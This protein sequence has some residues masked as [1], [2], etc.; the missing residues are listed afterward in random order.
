M[1]Y[2]SSFLLFFFLF[3]QLVFITF[4]CCYRTQIKTKHPKTTR[5]SLFSFCVCPFC[6]KQACCM[7]IKVLRRWVIIFYH[8]RCKTLVIIVIAIKIRTEKHLSRAG[9]EFIHNKYRVSNLIFVGICGVGLSQIM[10]WLSI[11]LVMDYNSR[12]RIT[13][14]VWV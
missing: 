13:G 14:R 9:Q 12:Y 5:C 11:L 3:Y 6:I 1:L 4:Y 8:Y 7:L 10:K 2:F